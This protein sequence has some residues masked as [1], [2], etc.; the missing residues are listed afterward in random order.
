MDCT[1]CGSPFG[2]E[3]D[4]IIPKSYTNA[5]FTTGALVPAC[6]ECN[7]HLGSRFLVGVRARAAF[8]LERY[9]HKNQGLLRGPT[10][11]EEEM[12]DM[13]PGLRTAVQA[14]LARQEGLR[15]RLAHLKAVAGL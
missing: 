3:R 14:G 6:G 15:H 4:H 10:W 12:E 1:Y 7:T 2:N 9:R 8:L 13:G 5:S 11:S